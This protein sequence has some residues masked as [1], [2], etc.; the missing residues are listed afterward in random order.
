MEKPFTV[1][2]IPV[3]LFPA[4]ICIFVATAQTQRPTY[5]PPPK[6]LDNSTAPASPGKGARPMDFI[7]LQKEANALA[8]TAQTIPADIATVRKGIMP[9]DTI[10]KLKQIEKLS[11][12]LRSELNP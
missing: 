9:Q 10:Q 2:I 4:L 12:R 8:E 3:L 6:P 1:P 11:K 7:Q 5:P